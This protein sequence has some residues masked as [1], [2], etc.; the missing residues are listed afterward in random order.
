MRLLRWLLVLAIVIGILIFGIQFATKNL[1]QV[2]LKIP[3]GWETQDVELWE[4]VLISAGAGAVLAFLFFFVELLG[5]E[6][7]KRRLSQR[8]KKV[9]RE[10]NALRNLPLSQNVSVDHPK[11]PSSEVK[12]TGPIEDAPSS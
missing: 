5:V 11:P 6:V 3:G 2:S 1:Q 10:L 12:S 9:E 4:L 7:G 8:L